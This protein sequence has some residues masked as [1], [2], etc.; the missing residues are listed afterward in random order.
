M[1]A[2]KICEIDNEGFC[3]AFKLSDSVQGVLSYIIDKKIINYL[4]RYMS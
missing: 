3:F 2:S 1:H 4:H